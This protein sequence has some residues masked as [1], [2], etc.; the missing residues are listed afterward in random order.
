[1]FLGEDIHTLDD[2]GRVVL[3]ARFRRDLADGCVITKGQ[4]G[5]LLVFTKEVYAEKATEVMEKPLDTPGRR[6]ARTFF[7]SADEQNL[8]KAGRL[9]IKPDLRGY[10]GLELGREVAV[11]GVF[12]HIELWNLEAHLADRERGDREFLEA[13]ET[14]GEAIGAST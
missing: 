4:D 9:L 1:V 8:D 12:D 3:P 5:Q 2:K 7:S 11:L 14:E 10:A 6:F 13:E